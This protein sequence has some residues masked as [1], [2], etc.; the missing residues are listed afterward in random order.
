MAFPESFIDDLISRNDIV[1][2]VESYVHLSKRSG[3]NYFGLCP[4][5]NERTPSF[6]VNPSEQFYYCFGCGKGGGVINFIME[7]ENLSYP[8]A[9]AHL[10]QR[11]GMKLPEERSD[12]NAKKRSRLLALNKDAARYFYQQLSTPAGQ[13]GADYIRSRGISPSIANRFGLGYAPDSFD[14][15]LKAMTALGYSEYELFDC[16]LIRRSSRGNFYDTFR[17]RLIFPIIDV[18]GDVIGFSGRIIGNG[19]PKYLNSRDTPVFVKGR[20]LFALNLAKKSKSGYMILSEGNIDI[21]SLHQAGF[22]SAVASL[23]TS[24]TPEQARLLSRYTGEI[25]LA[26]DNDS[27]GQKATQRAIEIFE[28]LEIK[29]RVLQLPGA[30]DPDEF[31]KKRGAD[32][33]RLLLEGSEDQ[34][35]YRM[36]KVQ[37]KYDLTKDDQRVAYLREATGLLAALPD[38][39]VRDVYGERA[40]VL[41]GVSKD[42]VIREI[43]RTRSGM[44]KKAGRSVEKAMRRPEHGAQPA[45]QKTRYQNPASAVA[46]EGIIRLLFLDPSLSAV[47]GLPSAD[48]FTSEDLASIY[49]VLLDRRRNGDTVSISGLSPFLKEEEMSLLVS[50]LQKPEQLSGSRKTMNDYIHRMEEEKKASASRT[51]SDLRT[52]ASEYK[53]RKG[54]NQ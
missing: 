14:S 23:G 50:I 7:I 38:P 41:A 2:V 51:G 13:P 33:F 21:V 20:N 36:S 6:S 31:L 47:E 46:E 49:R 3:S 12:P 43:E 9:V 25:I 53:E 44:I 52:I 27:A 4:F 5:H 11:A 45:L 1:E 28:K 34:I 19:E 30:K 39:V 42:T 35:D 22:D 18:R 8:D 48:D 15:L 17:N 40:A 29:V 32:A 10:A 26:F 24:L 16:D 54:Y 37:S